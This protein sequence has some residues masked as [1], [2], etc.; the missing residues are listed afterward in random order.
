M[1]PCLALAVLLAPPHLWPRASSVDFWRLG[2]DQVNSSS[3]KL[4]PA[5]VLRGGRMNSTLK[6]VLQRDDGLSDVAQLQSHPELHC[7]WSKQT[8][9][10]ALSISWSSFPAA[11]ATV[12]F[13]CWRACCDP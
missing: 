7:T 9:L 4:Q 3:G 11:R 10:C 1:V 12:S 6:H 13:A 2:L 5:F 8:K